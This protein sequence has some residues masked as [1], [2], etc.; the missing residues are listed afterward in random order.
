MTVAFITSLTLTS[1]MYLFCIPKRVLYPERKRETANCS[2]NYSNII[3]I[4]HNSLLKKFLNINDFVFISRFESHLRL[5]PY[6]LTTIIN[7]AQP[8][9]LFYGTSLKVGENISTIMLKH[10]IAE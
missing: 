2:I 10:F 1:T 9:K 3:S 5:D 8:K 6:F 4:T 7:V